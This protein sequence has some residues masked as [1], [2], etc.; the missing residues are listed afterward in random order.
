M[1]EGRV[2]RVR[3]GGPLGSEASGR[4]GAKPL[5]GKGG[6]CGL[7]TKE[8][9]SWDWSGGQSRGAGVDGEG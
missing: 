6:T 2:G 3:G 8:L 7:W 9:V 1:G 4:Q 5:R